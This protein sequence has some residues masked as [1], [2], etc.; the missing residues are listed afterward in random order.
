MHSKL[1]VI[2]V[3]VFSHSLLAIGLEEFTNFIEVNN[4]GHTKKSCVRWALDHV[5]EYLL[6][7]KDSDLLNGYYRR[8]KVQKGNALQ[9]CSGCSNIHLSRGLRTSA[10]I[11]YLLWFCLCSIILSI[12]A[13]LQLLILLL[14]SL[15]RRW[16]S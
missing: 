6:I 10:L 12:N 11:I 14:I 1:G 2:C 7:G 5:A 4:P 9:V 16:S 13:L 3:C 15:S 8:K